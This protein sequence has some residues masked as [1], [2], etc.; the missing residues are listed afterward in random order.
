MKLREARHP[1]ILLAV[2]DFEMRSR[3]Q[4]VLRSANY[5]VASCS[6]VEDVRQL[7]AATDEL[8]SCDLVI[9]DVEMLDDEAVRRIEALQARS[10]IPPLILVTAFSDPVALKRVAAL[11][12][13]ADFDM[14]L[15]SYHQLATVLK[16]IPL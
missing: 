13:E 3:L 11:K 8:R 10:E 5:D 15:D 9:C 1:R 6:H 7:L 4:S 12:T 16:I 14:P 2:I